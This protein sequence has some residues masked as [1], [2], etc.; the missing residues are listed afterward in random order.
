MFMS[1]R[2]HL[3]A[4]SRDQIKGNI[5][6]TFLCIIIAALIIGGSSFT[7][8]GPILLGPVF[9]IALCRIFLKLTDD[10]KPEITDLFKSFDVF[11]KATWLNV[12]IGFFT[13]LWSLLFVVPGIIKAL[14][15]SMASFVLA[16]NPEMTAREALDESKR[17]MKGN[18]GKLFVLQLSFILW[19][20]LVMVTFGI[21]IIYVG[22][23]I[24]VTTANFY[25]DIKL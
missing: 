8:V 21:A 11:G 9:A 12:L 1:S 7:I 19:F 13:F 2:E 25:K 15:Y 23:Y 6:I 10:I 22:P 18:I 5:G 3:K 20:L 14:S 4:I 16:E 24:Y 17:I